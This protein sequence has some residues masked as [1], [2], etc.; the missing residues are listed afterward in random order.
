MW[1]YIETRLM[2]GTGYY[3]NRSLTRYRLRVRRAKSTIAVP[4][5][6]WSVWPSQSFANA[7]SR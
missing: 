4:Y 1:S 3:V 2:L 5:A 6:V 7:G